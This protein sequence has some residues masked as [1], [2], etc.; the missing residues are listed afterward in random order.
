MSPSAPAPT[1]KLTWSPTQTWS[2]PDSAMPA[3]IA[4][5]W[6]YEEENWPTGANIPT[7]TP[8][9]L[10]NCASALVISDSF[11]SAPLGAETR[12]SAVLGADPV[13]QLV[14]DLVLE[15]VAHLAARAG[16]TDPALLPKHP[17]RLRYR[18]F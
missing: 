13:Q 1:W 12:V 18:V 5:R 14:H 7:R 9:S 8:V 2:T 10:L 16:G 3:S 15:P 4:T 17:K 11:V 6:S